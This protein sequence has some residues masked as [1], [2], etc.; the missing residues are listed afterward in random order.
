MDSLDG[1]RSQ[2]N[3]FGALIGRYGNRIGHAMFALE[4]KTYQV[5]KNEG[6]NIL[7]GGPRG[8]DKRV[9]KARVAAGALELTY[10]SADGEEGF[11]GTL[12]AKVAYSL[13][14][15]NELKIEYTATTDKPTVVNLTNHSYFNLAGSGDILQHEATILADRFTPVDAGLIPTGELRAV[16][17]TPFDFTKPTAIGA[18]IDGSE[19]RDVAVKTDGLGLRGNLPLGR[20]KENADMAA[21]N[22]GDARGY[23]FGF[24]GVI[25]GGQEDGIIRNQN[26]RAATSQV[27]D[28][29]IF[30]GSSGKHRQKR[31]E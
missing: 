6:D 24:Q 9:W 15:N 20:T 3:Y 14:D 21:V 23:G 16:K 18:R 27:G 11:P 10:V 4:G 17:G 1:Y 5:T 25:D 28:D 7:H 22:C 29:F 31:S 26:D 30:L 19:V 13:T 12:T 2:P 8:F